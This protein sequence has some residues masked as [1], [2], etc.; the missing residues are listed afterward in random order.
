MWD[1]WLWEH[2]RTFELHKRIT[3]LPVNF[4]LRYC[5]RYWHFFTG[6]NRT[7]RKVWAAP[8]LFFMY[9][10]K[11]YLRALKVTRNPPH[12]SYANIPEF[13]VKCWSTQ[14]AVT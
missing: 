6:R 13:P 12:R 5:L 1:E 3:I 2:T 11:Y 7:M 4:R 10:L 9:C 14:L 8:V